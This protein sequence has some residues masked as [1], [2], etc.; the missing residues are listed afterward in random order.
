MKLVFNIRATSILYAFLKKNFN[1]TKIWMLPV[2]TCHL[3]P[4][5]FIKANVSYEF[6]DVDPISLSIDESK[7]L[8]RLKENSNRYA[9]VLC[10]RNFG[11]LRVSFDFFKRLKNIQPSL[12]IIDDACLSF[13]DLDTLISP[14]VDLELYSTGYSKPIDLGYGGFGKLSKDYNLELVELSYKKEALDLMNSKYVQSVKSIKIIETNDFKSNWLASA[15]INQKEYVNQVIDRYPQIIKHKKNLNSIY[16]QNI[17][18]IFHEKRLSNNWRFNLNVGN[19]SILI[20][21]IFENGLFASQH[22][23]PLNKIFDSGNCPIWEKQYENII[24]L[25]NDHRFSIKQANK[26]C[27]IINEFGIEASN[28]NIF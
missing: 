5:C 3:I 28:E 6:I 14:Y 11:D 16:R 1:S 12:L 13:P 10:V 19:A 7:V 26:I 20:R 8:N 17:N 25:F 23:F 9:G 22:Y 27:K 4:A 15:K 21:K 18:P 2:N 24:N